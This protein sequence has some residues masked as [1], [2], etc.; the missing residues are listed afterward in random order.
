M[1]IWIG[2]AMLAAVFT[3]SAISGVFGMAGGLILLAL[4]LSFLPVGT[5]IAVQGIVQIIANGSRAIFSRAFIDWRILGTMM[6]GLATA[7]LI[8]WIA[9]YVPSLATVYI[10]V[11][12]M[13]IL[14]WIP[15]A[16]LKLDAAKPLHAFVCGFLGGGF[17]LTVGVSGP[18][19]DIFFIRTT[20]DRRTIVA[21]K[22][23][24]QVLSHL[25]KVVF[26]WQATMV[27]TPQEWGAVVVAAPFAIAGTSA[28]Y[29]VLQRMNDVNFRVWMRWIV[30]AIGIYY[31]IQGISLLV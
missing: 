19:I 20:L 5:A 29:W 28:G 7:G 23:A 9:R 10:A 13:P 6:A 22:A 1:S 15:A 21:T 24:M 3:T 2:V 30:T 4:L 14:V 26:Y 17:N 18:S 31:L 12:L 16:K 8:L 11:G 27:L 25:S